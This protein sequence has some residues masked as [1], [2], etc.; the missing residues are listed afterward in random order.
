M[1]DASSL[2][3]FDK[4]AAEYIRKQSDS[5]VIGFKLE[6]AMGGCA[7]STKHI[8]GSYQPTISVGTPMEKERYLVETVSGIDIYFPKN[9]RPRYD[10]ACIT[11]KLRKT[12]FMSWLELDGAKAIAEFN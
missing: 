9:M 5:I 10:T 6:P 7:C 4:G 8:T 2:F 12:L 11:I 1:N 3:F